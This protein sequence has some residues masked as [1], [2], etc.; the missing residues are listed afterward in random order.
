LTELDSRKAATK[1][2]KLSAVHRF[3]FMDKYLGLDLPFGT[4]IWVVT[5]LPE[6]V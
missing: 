6:T 4:G 3:L 5:F 1:V 2:D